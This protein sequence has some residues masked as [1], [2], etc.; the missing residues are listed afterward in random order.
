M[1]SNHEYVYTDQDDADDTEDLNAQRPLQHF[2]G[3]SDEM[4][5]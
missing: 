2:G 3:D 4:L 1:R 5:N